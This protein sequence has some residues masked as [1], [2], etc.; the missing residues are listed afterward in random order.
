MIVLDVPSWH[1]VEH[2][3]MAQIGCLEPPTGTTENK[4]KVTKFTSIFLW[5]DRLSL[6]LCRVADKDAITGDTLDND[7]AHADERIIA[8]TDIAN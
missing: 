2:G 6:E 7:T 4:P 1:H 8:D 3:Q 5:T